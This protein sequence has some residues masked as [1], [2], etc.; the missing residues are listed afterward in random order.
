MDT[1]PSDYPATQG[2]DPTLRI[3]LLD[4][5]H[6]GWEIWDQFSRS[7]DVDDF[8]PFIAAEYEPVLEAIIPHRGPDLRFLEWGSATGVITIIADL[9]GF[10]AYGIELEG[11]L[12]EKARAL[13]GRYDSGATFAK[14]SF[15]PQGYRWKPPGGDA[16]MGTIGAGTSGYIELGRHLDEFDVVFAFPWG[17]EEPMMLDLMATYG[18]GDALLLLNTV[19]RGVQAYRRGKLVATP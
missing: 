13:A 1:P 2:L 19:N 10:D 18:K 7:R 6:E 14:G 9:L 11:D 4:L 15:I 12:V 5:C 3:R 8:H 16:R 17:G